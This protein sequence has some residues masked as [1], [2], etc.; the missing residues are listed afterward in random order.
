MLNFEDINDVSSNSPLGSPRAAQAAESPKRRKLNLE[1]P[2]SPADSSPVRHVRRV[3]PPVLRGGGRRPDSQVTNF[4]II[5][6]SIEQI[7]EHIKEHPRLISFKSIY[8]SFIR[9]DITTL[10][11]HAT[12]DFSFRQIQQGLNSEV[13]ILT[14][15]ED[16]TITLIEK[17]IEDTKNN[18]KEIKISAKLSKVVIE[19]GYPNFPMMIIGNQCRDCSYKSG[20]TLP[21][22]LYM[23]SERF[24]GS[25][26]DVIET[27][28]SPSF[29]GMLLQVFMALKLF[30][31]N[32]LFHGDLNLGNILFKNEYTEEDWIWY[33]LA[34]SSSSSSSSSRPL[35]IKTKGKIWALTDFNLTDKQG[36]FSEHYDEHGY[37]IKDLSYLFSQVGEYFKSK[38]PSQVNQPI[39]DIANRYKLLIF[40]K[41]GENDMSIDFLLELL[42][43]DAPDLFFM[44]S[45]EE[46]EVWKN[47]KSVVNTF[48][49]LIGMLELELS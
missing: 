42:R 30:E 7:S 23:F 27:I 5:R 19:G 41:I 43:Q 29:Y 38:P 18:R 45:S 8:H 39:L 3:P 22:C 14:D 33:D 20:D 16:S 31:K 35:F 10:C 24:D 46:I 12:Q 25:L 48:P 26:K 36:V 15:K 17:I 6:P 37:L 32:N 44:P 21:S 13:Y 11:N 40:Q 47:D 4:D 1:L 2:T 28:D 9:R 49:Y 34:S